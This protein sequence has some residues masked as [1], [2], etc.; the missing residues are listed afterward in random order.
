M[1]RKKEWSAVGLVWKW[2]LRHA[3]LRISNEN[4]QQA[5]EVSGVFRLNLN[6]KG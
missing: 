2:N 1:N 5:V 4:L 3:D 6:L